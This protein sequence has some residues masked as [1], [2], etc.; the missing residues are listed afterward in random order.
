MCVLTS[1]VIKDTTID[2]KVKE[3]I[4]SIVFLLQEHTIHGMFVRLVPSKKILTWTPNSSILIF[5]IKTVKSI[6]NK[7][8][9]VN[10]DP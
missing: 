2:L 8:F 10:N 6:E 1:C 5:E 9:Q 3:K 7:I 4:Q